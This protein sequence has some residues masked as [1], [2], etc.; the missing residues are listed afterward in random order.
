M[1]SSIPVSIICGLFTQQAIQIVFFSGWVLQT[2]AEREIN[3][4][5]NRQRRWNVE[6]AIQIYIDTVSNSGRLLKV[7]RY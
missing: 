7:D 1:K 3:Y 4:R 2:K 6:L 5:A